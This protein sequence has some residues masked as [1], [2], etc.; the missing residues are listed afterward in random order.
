MS[1]GDR[2]KGV[3]VHPR[4]KYFLSAVSAEFESLR[5]RLDRFLR[6]LGF[7]TE[8]MEY[9]GTEA[10][11]LLNLLRERIDECDGF[12][13]IVGQG[14]GAEPP[15][16]HSELGRISYTQYEYFYAQER[17][18]RIFLLPAADEAERDGAVVDLDNNPPEEQADK[19]RLQQE[20][21]ARLEQSGQLW[22]TFSSGDELERK[23][24][25]LRT[26][27]DRT[28]REFRE[29]Q[30][31]SKRTG[32]RGLWIGATSLIGIIILGLGMFLFFQFDI[33][34][35]RLTGEKLA[36][37]AQ[38][39]DFTESRLREVL[40]AAANETL[41]KRTKAS[42]GMTDSAER[43]KALELAAEEHRR[44]MA[45][46]ESVA[47]GF[48][49]VLGAED[50]SPETARILNRMSNFIGDETIAP[51]DR[52][53][54]ALEVL[55]SEKAA[56]KARVASRQ[57]I[58]RAALRADLEPLI[59]GA[60]LA[61]GEARYDEAAELYRDVLEFGTNRSWS[62]IRRDFW[63]MLTRD[64]GQQARAYGDLAQADMIFQEALDIAERL[65]SDNPENDRW[66]RALS[67]SHN[68]LGLVAADNGEFSR[69]E[70]HYLSALE[71]GE[72]RVTRED[73]ELWWLIDLSTSHIHLGNLAYAQQN[74]SLAVDHYKKAL[75]VRTSLAAKYPDHDE[76]WPGA[77]AF[78][79]HKLGELELA[80]ND[81]IRAEEYLNKA[82]EIR[83]QLV[84]REPDSAQWEFH[85][86]STYDRLGNLAQ[87][88]GEVA[89]AEAHYTAAFKIRTELVACDPENLRWQSGLS[90]S[91]F[92]LGEI[93]ASQADFALAE[94]NHKK[95]LEIRNS[96]V[97]D[98]P[99]NS[100][101]QSN[102]AESYIALGNLAQRQKQWSE[103]TRLYRSSLE[104]HKLLNSRDP[105]NREWQTGLA[106]AYRKLD[107]V[108]EAEGKHS[109]DIEYNKE[110]KIE[111]RPP[112]ENHN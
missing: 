36:V 7:E 9:S 2:D 71:I 94:L 48:A 56:L 50:H 75:D 28:R 92:K 22:H 61:R 111:E 107:Q 49:A 51:E 65:N 69:A 101:W 64:S 44:T 57:E 6:Q 85:L 105:N 33:E 12:I 81:S 54:R 99:K 40:I 55:R 70:K 88:S 15:E 83:L 103:A 87:R 98:G 43:T 109:L 24:A 29:H 77:F 42:T 74:L 53:D 90:Y 86:S 47:R 10:G 80:Q 3:G 59:Q 102:L 58:E 18:M 93:A 19:H 73:G 97:S 25:T 104:V 67:E 66:E 38:Q 41:A 110:T 16:P 27:V 91:Q 30:V 26:E 4:P 46:V 106:E 14:Y 95:S 35:E 34:Q 52:I 96:L 89:K 11:D 21:R 112:A 39:S 32:T 1:G 108:A 84:A 68:N 37:I 63:S 82:L 17:G 13:Q 100:T 23:I 5:I 76:K 62:E 45:R 60:E 78:L 8:T 79:Y 31:E 72:L 20:Y